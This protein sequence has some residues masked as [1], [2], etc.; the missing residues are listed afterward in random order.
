MTDSATLNHAARIIAT[1]SPEL[2]AD[3]A[4]RGYLASSRQLGPREKRAISRAVFI[5]FRWFQWL[6]AR[7]SVQKQVEQAVALH[8]RFLADPKSVKIEALAALA[9]PAWLREEIELP[10]ETLRQ[11]QREPALWLRARPGTSGKL[12]AA[13]GD[14][15]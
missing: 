8:E 6:D 13:L 15:A 1:I 5:Y 10:A 4:L 11:F 9:V 14:C 2:R 7:A 12:A 3:A